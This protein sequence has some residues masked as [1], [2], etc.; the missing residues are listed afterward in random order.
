MNSKQIARELEKVLKRLRAGLLTPEE[1]K[2]EQSLLAS[3]LKAY[4]VSEI[5]EK[6]D[7]IEAVLEGR[8]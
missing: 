1:A 7:R 5:Q 4:E 8:Q 3:M 2:L 6:V